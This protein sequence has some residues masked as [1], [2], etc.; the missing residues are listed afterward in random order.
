MNELINDG[1]VCRRAPATQGLLIIITLFELRTIDIMIFH[2][3]RSA[4]A[5]P[6]FL[7]IFGWNRSPTIFP[8]YCT[9]LTIIF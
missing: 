7:F 6:I 4:Q 8:I 1:G 3:V 2:F 5:I 9:D